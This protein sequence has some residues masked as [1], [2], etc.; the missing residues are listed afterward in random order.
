MFSKPAWATS[1]SGAS[2][3]PLMTAVQSPR[4]MTS[5]ASATL[6]VPVAQA[7][8]MQTLWP[9]APVSMAIMPDVESTRALAMNVGGTR[10]WP[11]SF[12]DREAVD[13]QELAA[14]A[15]PEDD[16]D[17]GPV[18]VVDLVAG[19]GDRLLRRG[20]AEMHLVLAAANRLV[21][22]P[23]GRVEVADLAGDVMVIR[24]GIEA[25][26]LAEAGDAVEEVP[27][28]SVLVVADGADDAE[29]GDD[30]AT[31]VIGAAHGMETPSVRLGWRVGRGAPASSR[32]SA[33][34]SGAIRLMRFVSTFPGPTS[35]NVS[36]PAGGHRLDDRAD[37]VAELDRGGAD[38]AAGEDLCG[39]GLCAGVVL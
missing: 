12:E 30:D 31:G 36:T 11:R 37:R 3:E 1:M 22:H 13:H 32:A 27:P 21:L 38:A 35:M 5:A 18:R 29:A 28:G 6:C 25:R 34:A 26:D 9:I 15:R 24:R 19:V 14:G 33:V 2:V 39:R 10:S 8:T 4:R 23:R 7:E 20:D 16:A 17:V